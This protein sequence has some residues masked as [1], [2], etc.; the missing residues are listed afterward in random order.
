[1][2]REKKCYN[3]KRTAPEGARFPPLASTGRPGH[4]CVDCRFTAIDEAA[5]DAEGI[6]CD[7][8]HAD[9]PLDE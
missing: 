2:K 9:I 4:I 5:A 3:C 7:M 1:M 6:R 8:R